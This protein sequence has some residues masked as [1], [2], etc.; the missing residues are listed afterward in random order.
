MQRSMINIMSIADIISISNAL[1]GFFSI[2]VLLSEFIGSIELRLQI[3]FTLILIALI[4][5]GLDGIVARRTRQSEIGE[6]LDSMADMTS[7]VVAPAFFMYFIYSLI[8][9]FN[10]IRLMYLLFALVLYVGF[11]FLRLA[12]FHI[13][14]KEKYFIGLPVPAATIVLIVLSYLEVPFIVIL[15]AIVIIAALMVSNINFPKLGMKF[16]SVAAILILFALTFGKNFDGIAI[17]TLFFSILIYIFLGP[18][19]HKLK[20]SEKNEFFI[21]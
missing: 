21:K 1:L 14:K 20:E 6:Y 7:L 18:V 3:A 8:V 5:D 9:E 15:P 2:V 16:D 4:A 19:Y 10:T 12:S 13:M 17:W 11:G